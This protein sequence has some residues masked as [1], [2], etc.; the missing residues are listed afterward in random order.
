MP[1]Q[2]MDF[3]TSHVLLQFF[4]HHLL[5]TVKASTIVASFSHP[6]RLPLECFLQ[7]FH[8]LGSHDL[9]KPHKSTLRA[10]I[11]HPQLGLPHLCF[12]TG[13]LTQPTKRNQITP[14]HRSPYDE[15]QIPSSSIFL[16]TWFK[17]ILF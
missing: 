4:A 9:D 11:A 15:I 6:E 10:H 7:I 12:I 2:E 5:Q 3:D 16:F 14:K 13:N 17:F 1:A 8:L